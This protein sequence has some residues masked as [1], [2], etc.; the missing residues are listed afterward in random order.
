M[1]IETM[2]LRDLHFLM[3]PFLAPIR[4]RPGVSST[5]IVRAAARIGN[6]DSRRAKAYRQR[7]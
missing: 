7:R 4:K 5:P 6:A 1:K 3:K 2:P